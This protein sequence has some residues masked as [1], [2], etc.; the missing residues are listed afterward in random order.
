MPK[1]VLKVTRN[2]TDGTY[3]FEYRLDFELYKDKNNYP[4]KNFEFYDLLDYSIY[5]IH[6][7]IRNYVN[8]DYDSVKLFL[9]NMGQQLLLKLILVNMM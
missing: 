2:E 3:K 4:L 7:S 8:F 9:K 6:P 5:Y 1:T